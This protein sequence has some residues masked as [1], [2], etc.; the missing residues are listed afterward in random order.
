MAMVMR[1]R[2]RLRHLQ[3][4]LPEVGS[5][6]FFPSRKLLKHLEAD[7]GAFTVADTGRDA[8]FLSFVFF[9]KIQALGRASCM[10]RYLRRFPFDYF[11]S[12]ECL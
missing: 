5:P 10:L 4:P 11:L 3:F 7:A 9:L 1:R 2:Y 8:T 12:A 6:V